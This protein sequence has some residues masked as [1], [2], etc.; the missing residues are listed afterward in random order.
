MRLFPLLLAWLIGYS[1]YGQSSHKINPKDITIVRDQWGVPHIYGKTDADCSYGLAWAFAEDN[2][3][4]LQTVILATKGMLGRVKGVDGAIVDFAMQLLKIDSIVNARFETDLSPKFRKVLDG[5]CQG[6]NDYAANHKKEVIYKKAFPVTPKEII[7][8]Y[9][10][11]TT[12]MAGLGMALKAVHENRI[13]EFYNVNDRDKGSNAFAITPDRMADNKGYLLVNSHQPVEGPEA[14]YEAHVQSEEGWNMI[15]GTFAGGATLFIG[16]NQHLGWAHTNNYHS[17]GDIF[18]LEINPKNKKQYQYEG[19]WKDFETKKA[20]LVV[21][22]AGIPIK[23]SRKA[24]H[25]VYGPVYH[26]K[27]GVY[28]FRFAGTTDIRSAEQW[29]KMNKATNLH[30]FQD[31]LKMQSLAL[32]NVIYNDNNGNAMLHSGGMVPLRDSTLNWKNPIQGNSD[33]YLWTKIVPYAKMPTI[34]NPKCGYVYNSNNSP[35]YATD[36]A[37]NWKDYFLGLQLFTYNRGERCAELFQQYDGQQLTEAI[38]DSIKYDDAYSQNGSYKNRFQAMY[39][40]DENKYPKIA[41]AIQKIKHWN[42]RGN[43]ENKDAALALVAHDYLRIKY[44]APFGLLMIRA[45]RITEE[46]AVWALTKAKKFLLKTHKTLDVKLGDISRNI[47]GEVSYPAD[48]LREVMRATDTKLHNKSK[49]IFRKTGGD[50]YIQIVRFS[51]KGPEVKTVNTFG[52]S[53]RENSPHY[54]DQMELFYKHE[55][56]PMTFDK[57]EIFKNA[58]KVYSPE[59]A[60]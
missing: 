27:H 11:N 41:D 59:L 26:T 19:A 17:F 25:S 42:L 12:L 6:I 54:T 30:E 45:Q 51:G 40:L 3:D 29:Y 16:T 46:D 24:W 2:F 7:K 53:S 58:K 20:K 55:M 32:F 18:K 57:E 14:W 8:G 10:L 23:V 37:E 34:L 35:L 52:S 31:A 48:G 33:D 49:G 22:I 39:T 56:K 36:P 1:S 9:M 43:L 13:T 28:A 15:G 38:L 5:Y 50:C 4:N 60:P 21:K 44:K 47:R